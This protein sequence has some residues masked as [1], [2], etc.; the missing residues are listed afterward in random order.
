M[1]LPLNEAH[2]SKEDHQ[3][4]MKNDFLVFNVVNCSHGV[5]QRDWKQT[6]FVFSFFMLRIEDDFS[7]K[8][9][10][11]YP[12]VLDKISKE[13]FSSRGTNISIMDTL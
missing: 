8:K 3:F 11:N 13:H 10:K 12:Y 5:R 2:K 4:K 7:L 1:P 6:F 9:E